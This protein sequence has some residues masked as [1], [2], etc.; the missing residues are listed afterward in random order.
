MSPFLWGHWYPCFGLL[1]T[2]PLG[3]KARVGSALFVLDRGVRVTLH[4]PW[5]SPLVLHLPTSWQPAWPLSWTLPHTCNLFHIPAGDPN[6][7]GI[8]NWKFHSRMCFWG[9]AAI[10][11]IFH[12]GQHQ[13]CISVNTWKMGDLNFRGSIIG[14][15]ALG[16]I[17]GELW[18]FFPFSI[19]ADTNFAFPL[20]LAKPE[21]QTLGGSVIGNFA[22]GHVFGELLPFFPIFCN[23][24]HEFC[25][26]VNTW[27]TGDPNFRGVG[28][29]KFY[30][31]MCFGSYGHFPIFHNGRHQFCISI[32][33]RKT[34]GPNF[35]GVGN[36]KFHSRM[37]FW[38]AMAIFPIFHNGRH[39]FCVS[40]DTW[41]T[42]D[43]NCRGVGNWKFALG[44]VFG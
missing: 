20:T 38:G 34:G 32:D 29:W 22:L 36:R 23:G 17:F 41:K 43:P 33:T 42:R 9:A 5:D 24:R 31:R 7:R 30:S 13:F 15:F 3:F 35:K 40:A 4:I 14:S 6:F 26:S 28:N 12:N 1:V 16:H 21:T 18:A 10:F 44:C 8:G 27:K 2:S 39:Q 19:M 37:H 25:V 11:P